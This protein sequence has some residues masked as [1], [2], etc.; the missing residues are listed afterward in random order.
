MGEYLYLIGGQM[1]L[2]NQYLMTNSVAR[3]SIQGGP[4][5]NA[6]PLPVPLAC[7]SVVQIKKCLYVLGGKTPQVITHNMGISVNNINDIN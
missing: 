2:K 4:W 5:R 1:K 7:H 6:A 3:W